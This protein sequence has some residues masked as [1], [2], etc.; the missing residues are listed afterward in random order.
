MALQ[1]PCPFQIS[2][3]RVQGALL[4]A[5]HAFQPL[6]PLGDQIAVQRFIGLGQHCQ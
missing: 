5:E 6:E 2:Q 1:Q 3:H 4:A